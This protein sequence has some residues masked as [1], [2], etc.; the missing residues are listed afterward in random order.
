[1]VC[2]TLGSR[3]AKEQ[4]SRAAP[5]RTRTTGETDTNPERFLEGMGVGGEVTDRVRTLVV[6]EYYYGIC[7]LERCYIS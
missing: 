7:V 1:M 3:T 2:P 6:P 4:N 5:A